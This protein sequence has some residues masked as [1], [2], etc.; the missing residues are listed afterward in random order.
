MDGDEEAMTLDQYMKLQPQQRKG[1]RK[2]AL[3]RILDDVVN[4]G[5]GRAG[6]AIM[7]KL[8]ELKEMK[9][10]SQINDEEIYRLKAVVND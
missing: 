1:V 7:E 5:S 4:K 10:K 3:Q 2:P 6:D 8:D 9:E